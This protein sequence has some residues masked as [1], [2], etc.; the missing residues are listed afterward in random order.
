MA[1]IRY[2]T[3]SEIY[4]EMSLYGELQSPTYY[5]CDLCSERS[6][7][8]TLNGEHL[9]LEHYSQKGEEGDI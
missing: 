8:K 2:K 3:E 9:C 4:K 6:S 7:V 1:K 5:L